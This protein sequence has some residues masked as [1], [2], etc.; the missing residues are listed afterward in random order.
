VKAHGLAQKWCLTA[1]YASFATE[2]LIVE[3]VDVE[4][5][6]VN[7][8]IQCH[9]KKVTAMP[10]GGVRVSPR[11]L[12]EAQFDAFTQ[13]I[14]LDDRGTATLDVSLAIKWRRDKE[15]A[16][17]NTT[18][19]AVPRL[20]VS[21]SEPR[22]LASISYSSTVPSM[23][24]F[25]VTIENPSNHFLTFG[26]TMDPSEKFAFSGIKQSTLQLVP[27]SRRTMR[28]R[29]LPCIR[30]DWIGPINC[31][32]RDRYFQKVLKIAP[33]EGMKLDKEG[34]LIWVAPEEDY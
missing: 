28:L 15:G 32:I 14:S 23:I 11:S 1:R 13:K 21:S 25:D 27:L 6:A 26:L 30:G 17:V 12:E 9:T 31:V 33:T 7:G 22:V 19:L 20:L 16:D 3:D 8:G 10:D 4:V 29:L 2:E 34:L 5:L 24:H 18:T